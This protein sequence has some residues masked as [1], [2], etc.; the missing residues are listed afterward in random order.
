MGG[1]TKHVQ[2]QVPDA[3]AGERAD[4]IVAVLAG[5]SRAA[6][7]ALVESRA[8]T[9]DGDTVEPRTRIPAGTILAVPEAAEA[10]AVEAEPVDFAVRWED[11][12][13]AVVD[14]P[15][16]VVV[17]PGAGQASGTLV[18][19]LLH[20]WP[21]LSALADEQRWGLVHRLDR[22]TSGLLL[23]AK[24]AAVW[25]ALR[26]ALRHRE[27]ERIYLALAVGEFRIPTGIIDAPVGRDPGRPTRMAVLTGGRPS[28]T[29]YRTLA[30]WSSGVALLEVRLETG[31]T[32]QI[33]IHL[34]SIDSP[35]VGDRTYA[36]RLAGSAGD[37]GRPWLHAAR[38]GFTH[39]VSGRELAVEAPLPMDLRDS[40]AG[41]GSPATGEVPPH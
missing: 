15:A 28:R 11:E 39:P 37:P 40:L 16:G 35:L 25:D 30:T 13:L 4:R 5:V 19:G 26:H 18:A 38:L 27:I 41:L 12:F 24:S 9:F 32:H 34:A 3:L 6:A 8:A 10:A 1:P 20:R 22:G 33:R 2:H 7:R 14:K 21:D 17:H 36:G 23:V 31:R 29:H